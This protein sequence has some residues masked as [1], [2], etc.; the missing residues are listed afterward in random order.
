MSDDRPPPKG[1]KD[2]DKK[3]FS[4][5]LFELLLGAATTAALR[6]WFENLWQ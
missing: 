2:P 1:E 3:A 4:R 6:V 5:R